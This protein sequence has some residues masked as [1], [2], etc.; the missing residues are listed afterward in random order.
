MMLGQHVAEDLE[1]LRLENAGVFGDLVE[2]REDA[3]LA[4]FVADDRHGCAGWMNR[5]SRS[6]VS[7]GLALI[8][9]LQ[10]PPQAGCAGRG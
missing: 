5:G 6:V 1:I 7:G 9:D 2:I 10:A 4:D 8:R 3:P